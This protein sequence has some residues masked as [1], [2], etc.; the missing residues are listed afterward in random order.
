[1]VKNCTSHVNLVYLAVVFQLHRF[2]LNGMMSV[3][4]ELHRKWS[5]RNWKQCPSSCLQWLRRAWKI[6]GHD[7]RLIRKVAAQSSSYCPCDTSC[8]S[9]NLCQRG[10]VVQWGCMSSSGTLGC[11]PFR[12]KSA[13]AWRL[14]PTSIPPRFKL[15]CGCVFG[16]KQLFCHVDLPLRVSVQTAVQN[17][18]EPLR[19]WWRFTHLKSHFIPCNYSS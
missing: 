2:V 10:S 3:T 13:E 19:C 6:S 11:F 16:E 4:G 17:A 12:V 15:C 14:Q 9:H 18:T 1:M 5:W 8:Y 7:S